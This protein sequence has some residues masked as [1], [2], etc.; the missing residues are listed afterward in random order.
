MYEIEMRTLEARPTLTMHG[1][2]G[3]EDIGQ[4]LGKAYSAVERHAASIH[5]GLAG[6]PFARYRPLDESF[7]KFEVEAGFPTHLAV[8][9]AGGVVS[10]ELPGGPAAVTIHVGP[11]DAMKPAYEAILAWLAERGASPE[12]AAWEVYLSD[13]AEHPDPATWRTEIVQPCQIN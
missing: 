1:V 10:S 3:I 6:P 4:W 13:P 12:G 9:G 8:E 2:L 7:T 5:A 11:Y